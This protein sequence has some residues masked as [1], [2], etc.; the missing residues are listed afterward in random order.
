[1]KFTLEKLPLK[2]V[3]VV[4]K[5]KRKAVVDTL[6]HTILSMTEEKFQLA[7]RLPSFNDL[8]QPIVRA[9]KDTIISCA[10]ALGSFFVPRCPA[11]P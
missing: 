1:M 2:S 10:M 4:S 9:V 11:Y 8:A 5:I 6:D 3:L 7:L